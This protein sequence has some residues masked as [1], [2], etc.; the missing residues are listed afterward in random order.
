MA[1]DVFNNHSTR[2]APGARPQRRPTAPAPRGTVIPFGVLLALA[3]SVLVFSLELAAARAAAD[4]APAPAST[5][6]A[7]RPPTTRPATGVPA[8][9]AAS[10]PR[11]AAAADA[12]SAKQPPRAG[13]TYECRRGAKFRIDP[14]K[15]VVTIDG[16]RI[17]IADDWD[18]NGGGKIWYFAYPGTHYVKL[19]LH[20][21]HT[22]WVRILVRWTASKE[23]A[24]VKL[25]LRRS[26]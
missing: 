20:G 15:A 8:A 1:R 19:A 5:A 21:Y 25:D 23:V 13:A 9:A 11:A 26:N 22:E 3:L 10:A 4:D 7:S 17:G 6:A 16:R 14:D 12:R 24:D 2:D 18:D